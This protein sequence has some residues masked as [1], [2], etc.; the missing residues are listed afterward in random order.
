[1]RL[2]RVLAIAQ[3]ASLSGCAAGA[4][5]HVPISAIAK[6]ATTLGAPETLASAAPAAIAANAG[7]ATAN[8]AKTTPTAAP[9]AVSLA[10]VEIPSDVS[11]KMPAA[12]LGT[13]A[14]S[15]ISNDGST[16]TH[17]LALLATASDTPTPANVASYLRSITDDYAG[18]LLI[19]DGYVLK[20][21]TDPDNLATLRQGDPLDVSLPGTGKLTMR[22][23]AQTGKD[24][25]L[26]VDAGSEPATPIVRLSF[27]DRDHGTA[28][29]HGVPGTLAGI[30]HRSFL[31]TTFD[32]VK[33]QATVDAYFDDVTSDGQLRFRME[34]RR[35]ADAAA[36]HSLEVRLQTLRHGGTAKGNLKQGLTLDTVFAQPDGTVTCIQANRAP[37][38]TGAPEFLVDPQA[39]AGSSPNAFYIDAKGHPTT[40]PTAAQAASVPA[41]TDLPQPLLTDPADGDF[42][43]EAVFQ[44]P[45]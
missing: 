9:A 37:D 43:Q 40:S 2:R 41:P 19:L 15:I 8:A 22:L 11:V 45:Q 36:G 28:V 21:A 7:N 4:N 39:P 1:M 35:P 44:L 30:K 29:F 33:N 42:S 18:M 12:V 3:L 5:L 26:S 34:I 13:T 25:I 31:T 20:I 14:A 23:A 38:A 16:L 32:R 27:K 17:D 6:T 10:N 24:P